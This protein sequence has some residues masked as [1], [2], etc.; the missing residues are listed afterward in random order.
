VSERPYKKPFT[1]EQA[2]EIIQKDSGTHFDPKIAKAFLDI[3]DE[4]GG[5]R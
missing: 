3:A 2:V 1:H 4:I 5:N